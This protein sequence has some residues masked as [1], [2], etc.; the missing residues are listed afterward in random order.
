MS[1][2]R[3]RGLRGPVKSCTDEH[4]YPARTDA[5]G[6]THS[7]IHT[8]Y[9]TEFDVEGRLLAIV[10]RNPDGSKWMTS[11]HYDSGRLSTIASGA[12]GQLK[13]TLYIYDG[14]GKLQRITHEHKPGADTTFTYDDRGRKSKRE[15]SR[16]E[17]YRPNVAV[18]G[19]PFEAAEQ[20]P[21]L[22]S[23][24]TATTIYDERDRAIEVQV[25]DA[26][27]ALVSRAVRTYDA[28]GRVAE[29]HQILDSLETLI[30][31][32]HRAKMLEESGLSPDE[33]I[34]E[35]RTQ[36]T[37]LMLGQPGPHSV[38]YRYDAQGRLVHTS[39][40]VFNHE[41]EKE[42]T[43]NDHGDA[44]SEIERS[45]RAPDGSSF[46]E[47]RYSYVYD[48]QGNWTEKATS[49]RSNPEAGFQPLATVKR[50][51]TYY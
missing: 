3:Q 20:A 27:G 1:D 45:T 33:L 24:G 41:D 23:G 12:E 8:Q 15:T 44:E 47:A 7:A 6:R 42:I 38:S 32:E 39:R 30:P 10:H 14:A 36:L 34:Q 17:D 29:E 11:F 31:A 19:S 13:Q 2:R 21:N 16:P 43:Y 25:R 26:E 28:D 35:L 51:L 4:I 50:Q 5:D 40:R 37:T 18:G 48:Q 9:T 46:S 22:P 49:H